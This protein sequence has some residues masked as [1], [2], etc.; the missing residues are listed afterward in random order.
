[1]KF[2]R[3]RGW[4]FGCR[5]STGSGTNSFDCSP[6]K[7]S[8]FWYVFLTV[9]FSALVVACLVVTIIIDWKFVFLTLFTVIILIAFTVCL[10]ESAFPKRV[11]EKKQDEDITNTA[12]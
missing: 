10:K 8:K 6:K 2:Y 4:K 11:G 9:I 1:M 7:I 5:I 3:G 12:C